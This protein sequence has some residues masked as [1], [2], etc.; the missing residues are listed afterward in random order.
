MSCLGRRLVAVSDDAR[1]NRAHWDAK[2]DD[3]QWVHAVQL[4]TREC[5]W[6][7]WAQPEDELQVLGDVAGKD[8]LELG[9][10]AA[11]WSIF[12]A[13]RGARPVGMD[14]SPRQLANARRLMLEL[15]REVPL[16]LA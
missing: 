7:T 4:N 11:Q 10:G 1:L 15:G 16:V 5:A 9:C 8:V 2:S 3:Y 13:K 12:L 6:G 14:N